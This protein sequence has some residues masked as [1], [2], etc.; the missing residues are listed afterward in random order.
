MLRKTFHFRWVM[1]GMAFIFRINF[2]FGGQH[3]LRYS[4]FVSTAVDLRKLYPQIAVISSYSTTRCGFVCNTI[5]NCI[6]FGY[7]SSYCRIFVQSSGNDYFENGNENMKFYAFDDA[8]YFLPTTQVPTEGCIAGWVAYQDQK[9]STSVY[10]QLGRPPFTVT[11]CQNTAVTSGKF[12]F[13]FYSLR[14]DNMC[15]LMS[16]GTTNA[17]IV[18]TDPIDRSDAYYFHSC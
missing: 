18:P 8:L 6:G 7:A 9:F 16:T 17:D 5:A 12:A 15:V 13:E 2:G 11:D 4:R 10:I 1:I 3:E 14:S